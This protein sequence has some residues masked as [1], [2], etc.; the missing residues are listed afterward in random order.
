MK[1]Q[2]LFYIPKSDLEVLS[3]EE[4]LET[5]TVAKTAANPWDGAHDFKKHNAAVGYVEPDLEKQGTA[6]VETTASTLESFEE[7]AQDQYDGDWPF[8]AGKTGPE[9]KIWHLASEFSQLKE[10]RAQLDGSDKVVRIAHFDTGY[11]AGH[12]TFPKEAM[13]LQLQRNFVEEAEPLD[14]HDRASGGTGNNPGHGVGTLSILAGGKVKLAD[15][16]FDDYLGIHQSV[17][18]VPIRLSKSV[19]FWKN[20][21]FVEALEYIISLY[22]NAAT[23][24]AV[25]TMSMGG[26][27]LKAWAD[28]VNR[29]YEKGILIVAAT[30]DNIGRATPTSVIYPARFGRVI[31]AAGVAHDFSPY[32]K[33]FSPLPKRLKIMQGNFGPR[34]AMHNALAA[35]S[36]NVHW[37]QIG[38]TDK[39]SIRG[40]GT[41]ASTPQI[42]AAAALYIQKYADELEAL[43][44]GWMRVE[45]VRQA[46]YASA[47][48]H[49]KEG[50]DN[51]IELYFGR[52]ILQA[53]DLLNVKPGEVRIEKTP[54]DTVRWPFLKLISEIGTKEAFFRPDEDATQMYETEVL[55]LIQQSRKLQRLLHDE[56]VEFEALTREE[57]Q[58]FFRTLLEMPEASKHLKA[59]IRRHID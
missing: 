28:V 13:E 19:I 46:L 48:R 50:Y 11:D 31:A 10:A 16:G 2:T 44:E 6:V 43:P 42:A 30:G 9:R 12:S 45:T 41:S 17:K 39:V 1:K 52:G 47:R 36:P 26:L 20:K 4:K 37:A 24:C 22:D 49:I 8:P 25:V 27:P 32:Y 21:A 5:L 38:T 58:A 34:K 3:T 51:D 56:E 59:L 35:F 23:R 54:P 57:Q 33:P 15:Y 55:Q 18:I 29:A 53:A 14:A 7:T 40:A